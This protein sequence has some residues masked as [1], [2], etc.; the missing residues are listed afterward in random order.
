MSVNPH[1]CP[2]FTSSPLIVGILA[3]DE[4]DTSSLQR[5]ERLPRKLPGGNLKTFCP[6][7]RF[8]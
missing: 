6:Q 5:R 2:E 4:P 7:K 1:A 3:G 8:T